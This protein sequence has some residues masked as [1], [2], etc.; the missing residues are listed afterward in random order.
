MTVLGGL[1]AGTAEPL[2]A[3]W[4]G[5]GI[6]FALF[7]A[8]GEK[9]ELCLFD[10][11][12]TRELRR[13]ALPGRTGDIWH[14]YLAGGR[15][16][17]VYGYRVHGP[18]APER[19][20]RF[21]PNKLLLDPY[22]R[23]ITGR[24]TWHAANLDM[25]DNAAVV[26]KGIV[27]HESE[28]TPERPNTSWRDTIIYEMHVRG[29][30]RLHPGIPDHQRGTFEGLAA[31]E[32]LAHLKTLG[33]TAVEL[34]PVYAF[35]DE[36]HLARA[37]LSNYWGYNP[38]SFFASE[39]RYGAGL[40]EM[41]AAYHA[42]GIEVILDVVYNHTGEGD[43]FGPTLSFR[44]IDNAS[45]YWLEDAEYVNYSGC[46]NVLNVSHPQVQRLVLDSLCSW[47]RTAGVDGFRFDLAGTL[48]R[49]RDGFCAETSL[50]SLIGRDPALSKLKLIAEP[51]DIAG[52]FLG[53]LPAPWREWND[54]YRD[55]VRGFWRGDSGT[56]GRMATALA[57]SSDVVPAPLQSINF[58]T[59]HDGFTL[60]DLVSFNEKHNEAN[61]EENRDGANHSLSRDHGADG[62]RRKRAII[63]SLMLSQGIPML[64]A[65]D[66]FGQ[67][68]GGNNNAYCQ[69]NETTWLDWSLAAKK[70]DLVDFTKAAIA[71]R[72][73][74]PELRRETFFTGDGDITW[75]RPGGGVMTDADWAASGGFGFQIGNRLRVW[76]NSSEPVSP[77]WR[78]VLV[79]EGAVTVLERGDG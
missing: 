7:S 16:G 69:D 51:W 48:A 61:G 79:V 32:I 62:P 24:F 52:H 54:R 42:A 20:H 25:S 41:V 71:L 28:P 30:T 75:L 12:G 18:Y 17:Q 72:K 76:L 15:P 60:Q 50:L 22:A 55:A 59:A 49:T 74:Y 10:E 13:L 78:E 38:V 39:P 11:S 23:K 70:A 26:P 45:Y 35:T 53:K 46:G 40:C 37:G 33:V 65:G 1:E 64:L 27:T 34:L 47:A 31:P 56:A 29:M 4:D 73:A 19:G 5:R 2:G 66:E 8:N 6:N 57:G 63:A 58:V 44:G 43:K 68:Q 21:N 3:S 14:G 9:V 77:P 36:T 67:T